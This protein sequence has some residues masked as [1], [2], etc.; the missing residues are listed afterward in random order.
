[1]KGT[2]CPDGPAGSSICGDM[3]CPNDT[4]ICVMNSVCCAPVDKCGTKCCNPIDPLTSGAPSFSHMMCVNEGIELCCLE[5]QVDIR[6]V[7]CYPGE[8]LVGGIRCAPGRTNCI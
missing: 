2:C 6:G 7:C 5:G 4:D 3:C 8:V 1:M